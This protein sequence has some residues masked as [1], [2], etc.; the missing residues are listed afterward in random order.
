MK[1]NITKSK[2]EVLNVLWKADRP[3]SRADILEALSDKAWKDNSIHLK[4]DEDKACSQ[5]RGHFPIR[6]GVE[7]TVCARYYGRRI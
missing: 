5:R 2:F 4:R 1:Y 6:E 3:L 7:K